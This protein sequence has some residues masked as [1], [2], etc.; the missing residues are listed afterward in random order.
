ME[1]LVLGMINESAVR[2]GLD[3]SHEAVVRAND[4]GLEALRSGY[5]ADESFEFA[6]SIL[7][8]ATQPKIT[9]DGYAAA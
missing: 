1:G 7:I 9:T 3:A 4:I 5:G 6:R 8:S 2:L